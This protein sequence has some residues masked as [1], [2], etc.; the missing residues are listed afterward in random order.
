MVQIVLDGCFWK[1]GTALTVPRQFSDQ[2]ERTMNPKIISLCIAMMLGGC[3]VMAQ[4]EAFSNSTKGFITEYFRMIDQ[5]LKQFQT[6]PH[7]PADQYHYLRPVTDVRGGLTWITQ[8]FYPTAYGIEEPQK[9][10]VL[11]YMAEELFSTEH[12]RDK[13]LLYLIETPQQ[14]HILR[15]LIKLHCLP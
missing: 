13:S 8:P 11:A 7:C 3:R 1:R 4:N 9:H 14:L 5:E 10:P 15:K 2:H 12:P 6:C